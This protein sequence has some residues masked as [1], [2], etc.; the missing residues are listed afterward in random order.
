[1]ASNRPLN[2][3]QGFLQALGTQ[4][5][6][7]FENRIPQDAAVVV[8]SNHRSFMD[9][10]VLMVGLQHPLRTAC[11][12]YMGEVPLLR[13]V[14]ELLGCFPLESQAQ[15]GTGFLRQG[16]QILSINNW[17]AV[18]PEGAQPM[19]HLTAPTEITRFQEGFAHLLLRAKV[20]NLAVLPVAIA[21]EQEQVTSTI[22]LKIL[23]WF[24]PSEALFNQ[25]R[26]HPMVIYER[27]NLLIG[28]PYWITPKMQ[29][30]Y[31]GKQTKTGILRITDYCQQEIKTLLETGDSSKNNL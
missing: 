23:H 10:M 29:K 9:P 24:D 7:Y 30:Q 21:S 27:I 4:V 11:H 26:L 18:F 13:E 8:V 14:V 28:R 2:L 25:W 19:V 12:H 5:F 1:M 16:K 22:P 3:S 17:L 15:R 20:S 6:V 31:R